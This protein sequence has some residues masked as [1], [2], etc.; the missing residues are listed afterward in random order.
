[1]STV[2]TLTACVVC[3]VMSDLT[4]IKFV[5]VSVC[6]CVCVC[7]L[8]NSS[9]SWLYSCWLHVSNVRSRVTWLTAS[10]CVCVCVCVFSKTQV[11]RDY[12]VVD[13]CSEWV[14]PSK[15]MKSVTFVWLPCAWHDSPAMHMRLAMQTDQ[16]FE[17]PDESRHP[18]G[19]SQSHLYGIHVHGKD[20]SC[21]T[22]ETCHTE[23]SS[24]CMARWVFV[25]TWMKSVTFVWH[26]CAWQRLIVAFEWV[27]PYTWM[28]H[29]YGNMS[30]GIHMD[31]ARHTSGGVTNMKGLSRLCFEKSFSC[32]FIRVNTSC[33]TYGRNVSHMRIRHVTRIT[34]HGTHMWRVMREYAN[35][36]FYTTHLKHACG[37]ALSSFSRHGTY[38]QIREESN[39]T[40]E[41]FT[42]HKYRYGVAT[43][44]RIDTI[45]GL[46]CRISSLS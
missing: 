29:L 12:T 16:A 35:S 1:M 6:V 15:W 41:R 26:P 36:S 34:S 31:E 32:C 27:L 30:L 42:S 10:V 13:T 7:L 9:H 2:T 20:S 21:N 40:G 37:F 46:F 25:Y 22:N 43:V 19:W 8:Q 3:N 14:L 24:I 44:S 17:W 45:I 23:R 4:F 11:V 5:C 39:H 33:L 28:K 18:H 38:I